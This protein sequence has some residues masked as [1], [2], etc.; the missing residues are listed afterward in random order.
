MTQC[1]LTQL[2]FRSKQLNAE[3]VDGVEQPPCLSNALIEEAIALQH[4][5]A[6]SP[7]LQRAVRSDE[8][9]TISTSSTRLAPLQ[10]PDAAAHPDPSPHGVC[11]SS[12]KLDTRLWPRVEQ[13]LVIHRF[14]WS[15][16]ATV[17][18]RAR[19]ALALVML[20][21]TVSFTSSVRWYKDY[22][23]GL[24]VYTASSLCEWALVWGLA[25]QF[26]SY[27]H[28]FSH[29]HIDAPA[30]RLVR[31]DGLQEAGRT[32][33]ATLVSSTAALPAN[34]RASSVWRSFMSR[35]IE[36]GATR[37]QTMQPGPP[38]N[39]V[40]CGSGIVALNA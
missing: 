7:S 34:G 38:L 26:L 37:L 22:V 19:I 10:E 13:R 4:L 18:H 39:D 11:L 16:T 40:G 30:V 28:E 31:I 12:A 1:A 8:I 35:E 21:L 32:A 2:V 5:P 3:Q 36:A 24:S 33:A 20:V 25:L 14:Y 9:S 23:F 29:A 27:A 17:L 15:A 6:P